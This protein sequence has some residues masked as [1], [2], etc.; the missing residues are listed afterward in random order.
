MKTSATRII[1]R[2][3]R[4]SADS[5]FFKKESQ[6]PG[7]FADT[8]HDTFFQPAPNTIQRKCA[9]CEEEEKVQ[10]TADKKEG[11]KKLQRLPEKTDEG[12]TKEKEKKVSRKEKGSNLTA[13]AATTTYVHTLDGKGTSLPGK[14]Q[15]FFGTRMG[16]DFNHVKI[17]TGPEAEHSAKEV[18]ARAYTVQNHIVFNEGQFDPDSD[19]GKKLLAHE[20][21]HVMQKDDKESIQRRGGGAVARPTPRPLARTVPPRRTFNVIPG[22]K[23]KP[24]S[25]TQP[26]PFRPDPATLEPAYMPD[27]FDD[28]IEARIQIKTRENERT[29]FQY[30][31]E[32]PS[33]TLDRGSSPPSHIT[34]G[35]PRY[36]DTSHIGRVYYTPQYFH[37]LD[38]LDYDV[39]KAKNID[40][41]KRIVGS[42]SSLLFPDKR[43]PGFR[44]FYIPPHI[45]EP[46]LKQ[47]VLNIAFERL[48]KILEIDRATNMR[49][50]LDEAEAYILKGKPRLEGPCHTKLVPRTPQGKKAD[51]HHQFAEHVGKEK[52]FAKVNTELKV[53]TPEGISYSF[54][55][56]NPLTQVQ[57]W[58]AK[59]MHEWAGETGIATAGKRLAKRGGFERRFEG[60]D[61]QRLRGLYVSMRCGLDFRYVFDRCEAALGMRDQW[62]NVPLVEYIPF[63][64]EAREKCD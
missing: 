42:Y 43:S 9:G 31:H 35:E 19:Q 34:K 51:R 27:R 1:R 47:A 22:G 56:Y 8:A 32:T 63:P 5:A 45:D 4:T 20:L 39:Q 60:L 12:I 44:S 38:K 24:D 52:G 37:V 21:V 14:A 49:K 36:H 59:T 40:D 62:S 64:G 28:S 11:E 58:E 33:L 61:E 15:N 25:T 3:K 26:A 46:Q 30:R 55:V 29:N 16:Y 41:L 53:T 48:K 2:R 7:F 13:P 10:C 17:H 6:E 23:G 50:A 57:V 54:D 18:N